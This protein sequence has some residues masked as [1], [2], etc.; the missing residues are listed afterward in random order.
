MGAHAG[1]LEGAGQRWQLVLEWV[2]R[3]CLAQKT[4][5]FRF[6]QGVAALDQH[7]PDLVACV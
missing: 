3:T 7:L 1:G 5:H 2:T 6:T 4:E